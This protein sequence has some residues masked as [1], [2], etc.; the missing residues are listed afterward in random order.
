ME[1]IRTGSSP[2]KQLHRLLLTAVILTVVVYGAHIYLRETGHPPG[3]P[4]RTGATV[5]LIACLAFY[6]WIQVR[7][8]HRLDEY[9]RQIHFMALAIAFP[10]SFLAIFALGFLRAEG[11]LEGADPRDLCAVMGIAYAVGLTLA[12][13]RYR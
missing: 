7:V 4:V 9:E 3:D 10:T 5:T 1:G 13:R 2:R 8:F 12:Y 6:L 11:Y